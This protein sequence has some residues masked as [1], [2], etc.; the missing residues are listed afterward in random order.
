MLKTERR[1]IILERLD[2]V[3]KPLGYEREMASGNAIYRRFEKDSCDYFFLDFTTFF[4]YN[5]IFR[6]WF[7]RNR[8]VVER[9]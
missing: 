2:E 4:C 5:A 6:S 7:D 9:N 8:V 3:L 1:K